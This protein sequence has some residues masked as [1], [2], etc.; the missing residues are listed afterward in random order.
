MI[1]GW[2][3]IACRWK[4]WWYI[5]SLC[6][7]GQSIGCQCGVFVVPRRPIPIAIDRHHPMAIHCRCCSDRM[8][9]VDDVYPLPTFYI[10][11]YKRTFQKN[12]DLW[13]KEWCYYRYHTCSIGANHRFCDT[14]QPFRKSLSPVFSLNG[15][16]LRAI[17]WKC[18]ASLWHEVMSADSDKWSSYLNKRDRG[19]HCLRKQ[20]VVGLL[21]LLIPFKYS[22]AA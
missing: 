17:F 21:P 13:Y 7:M 22:R 4:Y 16:F 18:H 8:V 10:Y 12:P 5:I 6:Q 3:G 14:N 2:D 1:H 20:Y 15:E 19:D 11:M 9:H